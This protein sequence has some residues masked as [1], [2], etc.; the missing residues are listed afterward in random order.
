LVIIGTSKGIRTAQIAGEGYLTY[1]PRINV[2]G[3]VTHLEEQGEFVWFAWSN[4]DLTHTGLG[5]LGLSEFTG[6]LV[7]AYASDL[8]ATA[9]GPIKGLVTVTIGGED[10]RLF[11][12][13]DSATAANTGAWLEHG[14]TY[15]TS[16]TLNEGRFRW[17]I[18]E[19]K[20][21]VSVD[22]RHDTL[23]T[24]ESIA[25]TVAD[26]RTPAGSE[27]ITS[28]TVGTETPGIKSVA[29]QVPVS[30]GGT[31]MNPVQGEF[32]T[33]TMTLTGP[34]TSTPTLRRWTVRAIPM[35]FVAEVIQLPI[36]L[37]TQTTFDERDVYQ[38]IYD[39][40]AYLK[41]LLEN[42]NLALFIM[43]DETKNVYVSGVGY[44]AGSLS[45]WSDSTQRA[46]GRRDRWPEGVITVTLMT[47]QTGDT[48]V[49]TNYSSTG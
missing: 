5:R 15:V 38:D 48:L 41:S 4:Y 32:I 25:L 2:A 20:S 47:V 31:G 29:N 33:N 10:R 11:T 12:V 37:T 35:P 39:D 16:G 45:K 7:P 3:G 1:G 8:M 44:E 43:G 22:M 26:D 13:Y 17:G 46:E 24:G 42:R 36:I 40:Y 18:T 49:P 14:T 21:V 30:A 27:T 6:Q 9:Q 19:L 34:G 23:V 28:A